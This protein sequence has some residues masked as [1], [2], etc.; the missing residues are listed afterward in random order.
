MSKKF[1]H[2]DNLSKQQVL[3]SLALPIIEI[4]TAMK[5]ECGE[6]TK[7][8]WALLRMINNHMT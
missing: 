6:A 2:T 5:L 4:T 1:A 8:V 3:P 7:G